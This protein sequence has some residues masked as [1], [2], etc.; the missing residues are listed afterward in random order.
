MYRNKTENRATFKSKISKNKNGENVS[1][2]EI[3]E[4]VLIHCKISSNDY[5][6]LYIYIIYYYIYI[7]YYYIYDYIYIYILKNL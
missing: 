1:H 5:Q 3:T 7:I 6:Q 4:V 2:L